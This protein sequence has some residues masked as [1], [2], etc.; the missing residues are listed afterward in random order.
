M[1]SQPTDDHRIQA[2]VWASA[3]LA[4]HVNSAY[5]EARSAAAVSRAY[6]ALAALDVQERTA[7]VGADL[8]RLATE[9]PDGDR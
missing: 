2:G 8:V 7:A 5:D 1:S 9:V 6:A 3:A 4:A